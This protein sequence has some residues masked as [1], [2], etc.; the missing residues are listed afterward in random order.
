MTREQIIETIK[1]IPDN[2]VNDSKVVLKALGN[3]DLTVTVFKIT[4]TRPNGR[5]FAAIHTDEPW[6]YNIWC[7]TVWIRVE[8][9]WRK[10][11]TIVN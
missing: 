4:G 6:N 9:Q 11:R 7:G 5:R 10:W 1:T 2:Q 8:N 3:T